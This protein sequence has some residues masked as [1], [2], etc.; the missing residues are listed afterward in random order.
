MKFYL[1]TTLPYVNAD[2]HIGHTLEFVRADIIARFKRICGEDVFFNTGVDEHGLKIFN[3][4]KE[5][6]KNPQEY[7]DFYAERVR[8]LL[9]LLNISNDNFIR[10]TDPYH[11]EAVWEFWKRC[12]ANGFIYKKKYQGKY[13]ISCENF[14]SESEMINE[15]CPLHQEK[16]LEFVEEENYF[17][18]FSEFQEKLLEFYEEKPD[19][20]I[21]EFRFNEV[22]NFVKSGLKDFSIS[23]LKSKMP[24]GIEVPN[25]KDQVIYVWF[26]ALINYISAIG[27]PTD[28]ER[29]YSWWPVTQY[30]GKDNTRFQAAMWQAMLMAVGLPPSRQI[31]VNGF[32]TG[33]G[34]VKISKSLGNI[35]DPREIIKEYGTDALRYYLAREVNNFEDSPF[36]PQHFKESYNANLAN[37]LGNLI[38]RTLKMSEQVFS[39]PIKLKKIV[40]P[41]EYLEHL[42]SFEIKKAADYIWKEISIQNMY[43]EETKPFNLIKQDPEEAKKVIENLIQK[44]NLIAFLLDPFLPETSKKIKEYLFKNKAPETPLFPRK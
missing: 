38:S 26:D 41:V 8:E 16:E 7:V 18:K 6:G 44:I 3:K 10:T 15:K 4:A 21:P 14:I 43:I 34:G 20:V 23:R 32:I 25:D 22:K 37:N 39:E 13:C 27:W 17:F 42:N 1:T 12:D 36:D 40:F 33:P 9:K 2:L 29:F 5:S 24:W 19:F 11:R 31:I 28:M 30:C 35:V